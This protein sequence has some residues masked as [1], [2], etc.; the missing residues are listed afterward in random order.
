MTRDKNTVFG[1]VRVKFE[2]FFVASPSLQ[3]HCI[4]HVIS[5]RNF[6]RRK[7]CKL[8]D[9]CHLVYTVDFSSLLSFRRTKMK[10]LILSSFLNAVFIS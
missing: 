6:F 4:K 9:F 1:L 8:M 5:R 7:S 2:D 3:T 10:M